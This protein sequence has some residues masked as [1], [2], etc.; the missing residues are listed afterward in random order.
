MYYTLYIYNI[1]EHLLQRPV[2]HSDQIIHVLQSQM[3]DQ[4]NLFVQERPTSTKKERIWLLLY[5]KHSYLEHYISPHMFKISCVLIFLKLT[6]HMSFLHIL[7]YTYTFRVIIVHVVVVLFLGQFCPRGKG[8]RRL[9]LCKEP[10]SQTRPDHNSGNY[11][12]Y[13]L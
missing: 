11:V 3:L 1:P 9:T 4:K 7:T 8:P 10:T 5:N 2:L 6:V 13:S 12:R